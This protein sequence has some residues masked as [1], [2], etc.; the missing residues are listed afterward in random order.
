MRSHFSEKRKF[1][2]AP[3]IYETWTSQLIQRP[4]VLAGNPLPKDKVRRPRI[5]ADICT[6]I[7]S[8]VFPPASFRTFYRINSKRF[9]FP[10]KTDITTPLHRFYPLANIR[11]KAESKVSATKKLR[12]K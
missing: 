8:V 9:Y 5:N 3:Y 1:R 7:L 12:I 6:F 11:K 2:Q 10:T 4:R